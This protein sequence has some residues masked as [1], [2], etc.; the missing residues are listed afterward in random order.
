MA[1]S[2]SGTKKKDRKRRRRAT[3]IVATKRY[4]ESM[5]ELH[6]ARMLLASLVHEAGGALEVNS[7]TIDQIPKPWDLI[8]RKIDGKT[9]ITFA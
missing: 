4:N 2:K 6:Y 3:R 5:M 9:I 7:E 1:Q 8:A